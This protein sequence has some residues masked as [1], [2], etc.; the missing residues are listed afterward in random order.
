MPSPTPA[1]E[2]LLDDASARLDRVLGEIRCGVRNQAHFDELEEAAEGIATDIR[3]AFR[4]LP[5]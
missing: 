3:R 5:R 4:G 1:I 2:Q